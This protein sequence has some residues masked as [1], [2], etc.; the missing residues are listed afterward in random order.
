L[1]AYPNPEHRSVALNCQASIIFVLLA[2]CPKILEKENAKMREIVDKHFPDNWVIPI[3]QG[4]L[5]DLTEYWD[6]FPA[7]KKALSNNIVIENI[8]QIASKHFYMLDH[9]NKKLK[10]YIIEGQLAE[11]FVL[12]HI[13]EL[14]AC[15]RDANVTMRWIMIHR[16]CKN[17]KYKEIIEQGHRKED[18]VSLLLSL[19]KFE[20]LLKTLF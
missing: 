20:H 3:Y 2:F 17:K 9:S 11:E 16:H 4:H 5:V 12:D 18:L 13:K 8:K 10:S 6:I 19:S 15:L 7:A 14:L 1:S